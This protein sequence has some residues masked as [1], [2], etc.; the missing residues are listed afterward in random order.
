MVVV[1]SGWH[2]RRLVSSFFLRCTFLS[3]AVPI[4]TAPPSVIAPSA[5]TMKRST[6]LATLSA[7]ALLS[8]IIYSRLYLE[9]RSSR[10]ACTGDHTRFS[11]SCVQYQM[12]LLL[13]LSFK[14]YH[15]IRFE[16]KA[17]IF[18]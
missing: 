18:L 13:V 7:H 15:A 17:M 5:S 9:Q 3:P 6:L 4:P 8:A 12:K 1:V 11:P 14:N 2:S 10:L 16:I